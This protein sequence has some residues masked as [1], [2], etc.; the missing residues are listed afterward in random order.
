MNISI[1]TK[2]YEK[3]WRLFAETVLKNDAWSNIRRLLDHLPKA[4]EETY[5][6]LD[7][8]TARPED[9][10][11]A[12]ARKIVYKEFSRMSSTSFGEL[13]AWEVEVLIQSDVIKC[14]LNLQDINQTVI[15][16]NIKDMIAKKAASAKS[17]TD[18]GAMFDF[19]TFASIIY[20]LLQQR[21]KL[22]AAE[23]RGQ[24]SLYLPIDPDSTFK[25][26]PRATRAASP[27]CF[28]AHATQ[29]DTSCLMRARDFRVF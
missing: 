12:A 9:K 15:N 17:T 26:E 19:D 14:A 8:S 29:N 13:H 5:D 27:H 1:E 24:A 11:D 20:D 2:P 23:E 4:V 3:K 21:Q 28:P 7:K 6:K 18:R 22:M 16:R 10:P 25:Q